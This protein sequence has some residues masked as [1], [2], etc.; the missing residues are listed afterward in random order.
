VD[1]A[2]FAQTAAAIIAFPNTNGL[3]PFTGNAL[4]IA[5]A[6]S[7]YVQADDITP[8]FPNATLRIIAGAG[9]WLHVQQAE[10]FI[11]EVDNFLKQSQ[12][13]KT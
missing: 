11:T 13:N 6:L 3:A 10:A 4:F 7:N 8:L 12:V 9:H 5:G 1:L 2:I